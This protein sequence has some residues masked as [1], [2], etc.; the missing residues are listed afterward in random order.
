LYDLDA[1]DVVSSS[2]LRL[3]DL[4]VPTANFA[5]RVFCFYRVLGH[6]RLVLDVVQSPSYLTG[7]TNRLSIIGH[8]R[9]FV[10]GYRGRHART[11]TLGK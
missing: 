10:G 5:C 4:D 3:G 1:H 9:V 7:V 8:F 11:F 6:C 2:R